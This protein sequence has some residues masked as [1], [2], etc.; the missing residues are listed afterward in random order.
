MSLNKNYIKKLNKEKYNKIEDITSMDSDLIS[1][2]KQTYKLMGASML[3]GATGAYI[4]LSM[5]TGITEYFLWLVVFEFILLFAIY[6]TKEIQGLNM[7]VLFSF[8]FMTGITSVPVIASALSM[9]NGANI[10][11][12]AF[13][14]TSV[15]FGSLSYFAIKT[16]SDF[17]NM[18]KQIM[19]ALIGIIIVSI[20]NLIFFQSEVLSL[21]VSGIVVLIFSFLI[22]IDTQN[23]IKGGFTNPIIAAVQLYLDFLNMFIHLLHLLMAFQGNDD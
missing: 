22:I 13:L 10:I 8:A 1:F 3:A 12:N 15:A 19:F 21:V 20:I 6:F 14:M 7:I 18:G 5:I 11:G 17:R 9:P 4:G 16:E 23:L 2:V